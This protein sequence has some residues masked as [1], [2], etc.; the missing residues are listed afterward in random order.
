MSGSDWVEMYGV[1]FSLTVAGFGVLITIM[2]GYLVVAYLVG[3]RLTRTQVF[4]TNTL[5]LISAF[6]MIGGNFQA[7]LD[8]ST[9]ARQAAL[10]IPEFPIVGASTNIYIWPTALASVHSSLIIASLIFM[11]QVRHPKNE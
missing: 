3:E 2:S 6:T 8:L 10:Q 11:W 5:Y 4:V 1:A 9:A 7:V